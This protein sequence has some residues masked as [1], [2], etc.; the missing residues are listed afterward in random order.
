MKKIIALLVVLL[1]LSLFSFGQDVSFA[2]AY[3]FTVG[4][5]DYRTN[6]LVW[7]GTPKT[8]NILIEIENTTVTIHSNAVQ[9]YHVVGK[10]DETEDGIMYRM[11]DS[12]GIACN[13]YMGPI[14]N[15]LSVYIA[16]EYSDYSW[17]Y[18]CTNESE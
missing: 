9:K 14:E 2:R 18:T 4:H 11:I 8:C 7:N 15:S 5:R 13:M 3:R 16:I 10:I 17:I 12:D 6:E 1:S